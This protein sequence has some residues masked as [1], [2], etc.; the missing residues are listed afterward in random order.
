MKGSIILVIA[1]IYMISV[2]AMSFVNYDVNEIEFCKENGFEE[3]GYEND[4]DFCINKV[5][6]E[7]KVLVEKK[8]I[9]C[10]PGVW[11]EL[12]Y[13]QPQTQTCYLVKE[14]TE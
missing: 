3:Y 7:N 13:F 1:M 14:A 9:Y 5:F 10:E 2:I 12:F 8:T 6:E 4:Q 11:I